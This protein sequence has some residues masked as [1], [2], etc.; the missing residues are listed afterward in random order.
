MFL[1]CPR[2]PSW[3]RQ[4]SLI[5]N[6]WCSWATGSSTVLRCQAIGHNLLSG[7]APRGATPGG[8]HP[9]LCLSRRLPQQARRPPH[10]PSTSA[11]RR[12]SARGSA[13]TQR[14]QS[15]ARSTGPQKEGV[16]WGRD[17]KGPQP[18]PG[19]PGPSTQQRGPGVV[20]AV[21]GPPTLFP[22]R[23]VSPLAA[24]APSRRRGLRPPLT[25]GDPIWSAA[26]AGTT[27]GAQLRRP[28]ACRSAPALRSRRPWLVRLSGFFRPAPPELENQACAMFR[29]MAMPP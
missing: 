29:T 19:V 11:L 28:S 21:R 22:P 9:T 8:Q 6:Q 5:R 12:A 4:L 13:R 3:L 25:L 14:N 15:C 10:R 2:Q 17:P 20:A 18:P 23:P 1:L 27:A 16:R 26:R 24:A 7:C